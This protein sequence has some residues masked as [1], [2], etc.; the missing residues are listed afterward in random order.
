MIRPPRKDKSKA[1]KV[2]S[3]DAIPLKIPFTHG[4]PSIAWAGNDWQA[5]DIVLVRLET[6]AGLVGWG[7]AFSYNCRWAVVAM[8]EDVAGPMVLGKQLSDREQV[9]QELQVQMHLWGRYGISMFAISGIDIAL[10]DLAGKAAEQ[11][12]GQ[13]LGG[14]KKKLPAYASLLKY[15][16]PEIVAEQTAH[17]MANGYGLI[18]LHESTPEPV[19]AARET[20]G[21]EVPIMLDV[22]CAWSVSEARHM[23]PQLGDCNLHWLEEPVWPPENFAALAALR[24]DYNIP[25]AAGEN[26]CTHW[27]FESMFDSGAVDFAQPSVTKVGGVTEFLKVDEAARKRQVSVAPHS[28]YF[29]PGLLATAQLIS[30]MTGDIPI[31]RFYMEPQASLYGAAID[32]VD[33][34]FRVPEGPGLGLDPDLD[35][36]REYRIND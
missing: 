36:I 5:L 18:K 3:V 25:I 23:I 16:D 11:S 33:G 20:A 7:E 13:L 2:S 8:I 6:D 34:E 31:E 17:A 12:L 30:A 29:G 28:P 4:G 22:N 26:A 15:H 32:P 21:A 19:K 27:Q 10:W 9:I 1:V 14:D 24:A 35:V